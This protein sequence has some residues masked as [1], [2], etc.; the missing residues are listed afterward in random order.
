[1]DVIFKY[2]EN[3]NMITD[4][5]KRQTEPELNHEIEMYFA[6]YPPHDY[7]TKV[8]DVVYDEQ[9]EVWAAFL[10]RNDY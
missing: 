5:I 10:G 2:K 8:L 1:M 3:K 7:G 9:D 6:K 4:V